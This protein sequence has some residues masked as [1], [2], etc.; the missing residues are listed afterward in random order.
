MCLVVSAD[1]FQSLMLSRDLILASLSA[2]RSVGEQRRKRGHTN[3]VK[4][5]KNENI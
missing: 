5:V 1:A 4:I 3:L 2:P